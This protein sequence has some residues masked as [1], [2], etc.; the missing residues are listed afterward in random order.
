MK[1]RD[2]LTM[3]ATF[4]VIAI[5]IWYLSPGTVLDAIAAIS[6]ELFILLII[7]YSLDIGARVLRLHILSGSLG[8]KVGWLP[9]FH[10]QAA[11]LFVNLF[12]PARAGEIVRLHVL[13][14]EYGISYAE[15]LA[16]IVV[17]QVLNIMALLTLATASFL[18]VRDNYPMNQD[19]ET[20]FF[21]GVI[22]MSLFNVFI[23]LMAFWGDRL[24]FFF[25]FF[26]PF[27]DK[28]QDFYLRFQQGLTAL[29]KSG[30]SK[31]VLCVLLSF[32][33]WI[34]EAIMIF[35]LANDLASNADVTFDLALFA[36]VIGNM[37]FIFPV[38]PGSVGTYEGAMALVF[39]FVNLEEKTGA[40]IA[41]VDHGFKVGYLALIGGY[42]T[43]KLG[44]EFVFQRELRNKKQPDLPEE[45]REN[46][47]QIAD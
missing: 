27:E 35:L 11:T 46:R 1:T 24:S 41:A 29:R 9:L 25:G 22:L 12:T 28:L 15:G 45:K 3:A 33:V 5:I 32:M 31:L 30:P 34:F 17:E 23:I 20:L 14:E 21:I 38:L 6:I 2:I 19:I 18:Y 7:I 16:A 4:F 26:G 47:P 42:A 13:H 43:A 37:T 40:L 8:Y 44:K 39:L 10:A 36:S